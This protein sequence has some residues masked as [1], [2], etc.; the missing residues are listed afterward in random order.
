[1]K[2]VTL[3][4]LTALIFTIEELTATKMEPTTSEILFQPLGRL[5]PELSW[6]TIRT[7][8]NIEDLFNETNQICRATVTMGKEYKRLGRVYVK[9]KKKNQETTNKNIYH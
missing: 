5:I 8:I 9:C 3:I 7:K 2:I 1:M 6:A 4:Q